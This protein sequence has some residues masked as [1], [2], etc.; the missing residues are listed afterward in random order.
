MPVVFLHGFGSDSRM[1]TDFRTA[2]S[3]DYQVVTIDLPGAGQSDPPQ[4]ATI[5]AMAAAIQAVVE[6]LA[7]PPFVLI[8]HSMGGYVAL[9]FAEQQPSQLRGL[10]LFHSQPFP[11]T[12]EKKETRTKAVEFIQKQGTAAYVSE[13]IPKLFSPAFTQQHP[14][15]VQELVERAKRYPKEGIIAALEA[16]RDRPD[17]SELLKQV[18]FPVL[19]IIGE[20]DAAIP[21]DNSLAQT[22]LPKTASV[23]L[24]AGV[25]HMGMYEAVEQT[26]QLVHDFLVF[27]NR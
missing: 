24:L 2:F 5:E 23:H 20:E 12:A 13:F 6:K 8:G 15:I 21:K 1:W 16:I 17:R 27:C 9:A 14:A 7:L 3:T 11:D 4:H 19:F 26:Q 18:D 25:G 22:H 10:G